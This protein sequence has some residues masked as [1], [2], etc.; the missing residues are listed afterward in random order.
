MIIFFNIII[1]LVNLLRRTLYHKFLKLKGIVDQDEPFFTRDRSVRV[2]MESALLIAH[3]NPIFLA[4]RWN[5]FNMILATTVFYNYNDFLN[6]LQLYK[7]FIIIRS[8]ASRSVHYSNQAFRV[9]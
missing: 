4:K 6:F 2:L 5:I 1:V 8:I 7:I 9:W 3:P